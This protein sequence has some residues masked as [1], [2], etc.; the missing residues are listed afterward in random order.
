DRA[1]C[2][3][4]K[5]GAPTPE[6]GGHRG[7]PRL[8]RDDP[9]RALRRLVVGG[10]AVCSGELPC[11]PRRRYGH[12][13]RGADS[14]LTAV[15]PADAG[16]THPSRGSAGIAERTQAAFFGSFT[17]ATGVRRRSKRSGVALFLTSVRPMARDVD[18]DHPNVE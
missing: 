12:P 3:G 9:R 5:S 7:A 10:W 8:P 17:F 1:G 11:G 6:K 2:R 4:G 14:G 18:D 13:P 16:I 15:A